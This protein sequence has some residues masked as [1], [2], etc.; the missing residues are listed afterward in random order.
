M[1]LFPYHCHRSSLIMQ[2]Q[3]PLEKGGGYFISG[4]F[5]EMRQAKPLSAISAA[6]D[7]Y[8]DEVSRRMEA[9]RFAPLQTA[10]HEAVGDNGGIFT[11][12]IPKLAK[13]IG[14]Q[15]NSLSQ[16]STVDDISKD[17][18][19]RLFFFFRRLL[20]AISNASPIVLSLDD[21]QWADE[22][23]LE[24]VEMLLTDVEI[25]F[26]FVGCYRMNEV[27]DEHPLVKF[28][29]N[30][31][32]VSGSV[33]SH[34]IDLQN[35]DTSIVNLVVSD[36]LNLPPWLTTKFSTIVHQKTSGN[37]MF[38]REFLTSLCDQGLLTYSV[39]SRRWE[40]D[41]D[42]ILTQ[43]LADNVV[44]LVKEK[45]LRLDDKAQ[46]SLK[47]LA[48]IG[49]Q[50]DVSTL[51]LL[52]RGLSG[53]VGPSDNDALVTPLLISEATGLVFRAGSTY[54]FAHDNIQQ[55]AYQGLI[56]VGMRSSL[57]L[58]IG[59]TLHEVA[60]D[61]ELDGIIFLVV[62]Q[63]NRG[64]ENIINKEERLE[65]AQLNLRAAKKA[66]GSSSFSAA[67]VFLR[68][69]LNL[70]GEEDWQNNYNICLEI[71]STW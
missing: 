63:L 29:S 52:G 57:H 14:P 65:L 46:W 60:S 1:Y 21:L 31:V 4:K 59:R 35:M 38:F 25:R 70:L 34:N 2:L 23:S 51:R 6:L 39:C 54:R 33:P 40:W 44:D 49:A 42:A 5:D 36:V 12:L 69:A 17:A 15:Y 45:M 24:L 9:H 19:N 55:A 32:A 61:E 27:D 10:I 48:S 3:Q 66:F 64:S 16:P 20:R 53:N 37:P 7:S 58:L 28:I 68:R 43:K 47:I 18:L 67:L 30:N 13:F 56:P 50:C 22:A 26:L 71:Y 41:E 62:D 8:C 11:N